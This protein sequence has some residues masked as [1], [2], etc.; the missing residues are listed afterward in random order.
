VTVR[1]FPAIIFPNH[2]SPAKMTASFPALIN[3]PRSFST[4]RK[5][6]FF[7]VFQGAKTLSFDSL[8]PEYL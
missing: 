1:K 3:T 6:R 4:F 8:F 7:V 5:N 2:T